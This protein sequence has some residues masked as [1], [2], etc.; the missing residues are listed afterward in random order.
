MTYLNS[1]YPC[2][3]NIKQHLKHLLRQALQ[4]DPLCLPPGSG[5]QWHTHVH[6]HAQFDGSRWFPAS[7]WLSCLV[8]QRIS[9]IRHQKPA[10]VAAY[11]VS[12][13]PPMLPS[14]HRDARAEATVSILS[15]GTGRSVAPVV[16]PLYRSPTPQTGFS[17]L[18]WTNKTQRGMGK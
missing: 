14:R 1:T 18:R 10:P 6:A 4:Q 3:F 11:L 12:P 2:L 17:V 16:L 13:M 5:A 8:V 7:F 9:I 15:G